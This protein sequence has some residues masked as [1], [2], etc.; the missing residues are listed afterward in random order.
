MNSSTTS[1]VVTHHN[2]G[3]HGHLESSHRRHYTPFGFIF[4][5][6]MMLLP[7]QAK[8]DINYDFAAAG[9]AVDYNTTEPVTC[10]GTTTNDKGISLDIIT[11]IPHI[12]NYSVQLAVQGGGSW[13]IRHS[14]GTTPSYGLYNGNSG[15][16]NFALLNLQNGDVVTIACNG[17]LYKS[18]RS[19]DDTLEPTNENAFTITSDN[20]NLYLAVGKGD[21]ITSINITRFGEP[22]ISLSGS[23]SS[24]EANLISLNFEEP[25]ITYTPST[26]AL[27]YTSSNERVAKVGWNSGEVMF[28]NTGITTITASLT[29]GGVT[30]TVSYTLTIKAE[31]ADGQNYDNNKGFV[32]TAAG[33]MPYRSLKVDFLTLE[34]GDASRTTNTA[35]IRDTENEGDDEKV[36]LVSTLIDENGR[37]QIWLDNYNIPYQGTFYKITPQVS[38][39][40]TVNGFI[41]HCGQNGA[42][43]VN[44]TAP[45]TAVKRVY[46]QSTELSDFEFDL[47]G[48][49]TYYLYGVTPN[50]PFAVDDYCATF[51]LH[52]FKYECD[53]G[54]DEKALVLK[55]GK[56]YKV[57]G[58]LFSNDIKQTFKGQGSSQIDHQAYYVSYP[59]DVVTV[60]SDGT[61]SVDESKQ[62]AILIK[63]AL[64][65]NDNT[66][67]LQAAD[68]YV[69][70]IPYTTHDWRLDRTVD[71]L[72]VKEVKSFIDE[73]WHDCV[74]G[75]WLLTY[76]IMSHQPS[77]NQHIYRELKDPVLAVSKAVNGN[78]AA[79]LAGSDGLLI[80]SDS[81]RFG[82]TCGHKKFVELGVASI[83]DDDIINDIIYHQSTADYAYDTNTNYLTFATGAEIIV[84]NL[85]QGQYVRVYWQRHQESG[86]IIQLTNLTDLEGRSID[87][88]TINAGNGSGYMEFIVKNDGDISFKQADPSG[89]GWTNIYR[90]TVGEVDE[91][92]E[93]GLHY[94]ACE[95]TA[96]DGVKVYT[97]DGGGNS[98]V[99]E[100]PKDAYGT[101]ASWN[102]PRITIV[103]EMPAPNTL[104]DN[105]NFTTDISN[106][107]QAKIKLKVHAV[108][109]DGNNNGNTIG[110]DISPYWKLGAK[111]A[112]VTA[113]MDDDTLTVSGR[114][115]LNAI[116]NLTSN[117]YVVDTDTT[118]IA[119]GVVAKRMYPYTWDFTAEK[120][121]S[122]KSHTEANLAADSQQNGF[123]LWDAENGGVYALNV[124]QRYKDASGN[125]TGNWYPEPMFAQGSELAT[126]AGE[127]PETRGLG[128][129]IDVTT[130]GGVSFSTD[131]DKKL[132]YGNGYLR[133]YNSN[134]SNGVNSAITESAPSRRHLIRIPEVPS[135]MKV[136]VCTKDDE[137]GKWAPVA[138]QAFGGV[139]A[140]V[141]KLVDT[142][143]DGESTYEE[144]TYEFTPSEA[145][146][147]CIDVTSLNVYKIAVTGTFKKLN[148]YQGKSY[149]T[150]SREHNVK[151][152]L[153]GYFTGNDVKAFKVT[154]YTK[155]DDPSAKIPDDDP[156][157]QGIPMVGNLTLEPVEVA[158]ANTGLVLVGAGTGFK[159]E[160]LFVRDINTD[161]DDIEQ[162][163]MVP[164]SEGVPANPYI[165]TRTYRNLDKNGNPTGDEKTGPLAFYKMSSGTLLD[166]EDGVHKA[167]FN[168]PETESVVDKYALTAGET[169]ESG[170]TVNVGDACTLTFGVSGGADFSAAQ[171]NTQVDGYT[172]YTAGNGESGTA[173]SGT[174]SG[175]VYTINPQYDG[176]VTVAV[177]L[178][179]GRNFYITEDDTALEGYNGITVSDKYYGTYSFTVNGGSI[180]KV[181]CTGSKLGFYG[182]S[183]TYVKPASTSA[184]YYVFK[185]IEDNGE[186]EEG[187]E[188][189][190]IEQVSIE[191][192][193]TVLTD[194]AVYYNINGQKLSGKP[195]Q[196]G[197]YICNG[198]KFFVK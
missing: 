192:V 140:D 68:Y 26:A 196:K 86:D 153:S 89:I 4:L 66:L 165:L 134:V 25:V 93:T 144:S 67:N 90:I 54:Y 157:N 162:N 145:G 176:S 12:D 11:V 85:K 18:F 92:L 147:V 113:S 197:I 50:T 32:F 7:N 51:M 106:A 72:M 109:N 193:D 164:S 3:C 127:I 79:Y 186:E 168:M 119:V 45:T 194:N 98:K 185:F 122:D 117:G 121:S 149:A 139:S 69:I 28:I 146:D 41:R 23:S 132:Y 10:S 61:L 5:L 169:H 101:Y 123:R 166:S 178:N 187:S 167:Y 189:D 9:Q 78:N 49:E 80:K 46:S 31:Q 142:K 143:D 177:V 141:K 91:F 131:G 74:S 182:M 138:V 133:T 44:A 179:S 48:G 152:D 112:H 105:Y 125:I 195:T 63:S 55:E 47:V 181:Y 76:K 70:T 15:Q 73:S 8:A 58:T 17:T 120:Y 107:P 53:F 136:Y 96:V 34:L 155:A 170:T 103:S 114:G 27:T 56:L 100:A 94:N 75:N 115:T 33:K 118:Q 84:P 159:E 95:I 71:E 158:D 128:M 151:Y 29:V 39:K 183:Y 137:F 97:V 36:G 124:H 77:P 1:N 83:T 148:D 20:T 35:I 161:C 135:G 173:T 88:Q 175:T 190:G 19:T 172:A 37:Q 160:P 108:A 99:T 188:A 65:N 129:L 126:S 171:T 180:Y 163:Y 198:K 57:D 81:K 82:I 110:T 111:D 116:Q 21:Y 154:A 184:N 150:E 52:S 42:V 16:R 43:L 30:R 59:N 2:S 60:R 14:S 130:G 191:D 87:G 104:E 174:V 38:G 64:K 13:G 40:L 102:V 24:Y 6:L 22:T 156:A 62:G